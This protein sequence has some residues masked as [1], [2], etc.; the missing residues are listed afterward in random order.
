MTVVRFRVNPPYPEFLGDLAQW[1]EESKN[2]QDKSSPAGMLL[3]DP[4]LY[5]ASCILRALAL[6][7]KL[8]PSCR[9]LYYY[10]WGKACTDSG[11]KT[12]LELDLEQF[13]AWSANVKLRSDGKALSHRTICRTL[14]EL[15]QHKL[16]ETQS[17]VIT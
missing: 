4:S 7:T 6:R 17:S 14:K 9:N 8:N 10:I 5:L 3:T 1:I 2:Q 16:I 12:E 15:S 11:I 13:Q